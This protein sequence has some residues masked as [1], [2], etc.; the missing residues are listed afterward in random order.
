[1]IEGKKQS[2]KKVVTMNRTMTK[3]VFKVGDVVDLYDGKTFPTMYPNLTISRLTKTKFYFIDYHGKEQW[4][5]L[6]DTKPH[7]PKFD[8]IKPGEQGPPIPFTGVGAGVGRSIP[9]R[10]Y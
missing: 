9:S 1:M 4:G 7:N 5:A 3:T 10:A 6:V 2:L 8:N